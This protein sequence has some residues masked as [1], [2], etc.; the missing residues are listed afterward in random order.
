MTS[1]LS[2]KIYTLLFALGKDICP[3]CGSQNVNGH[4]WRGTNFRLTC[5]DCGAMTIE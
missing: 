1:W 3:E 5:N 2:R 4:G